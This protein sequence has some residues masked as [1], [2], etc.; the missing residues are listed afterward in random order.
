DAAAV[1]A[2]LV[3]SGAW[4][5]L[6]TRPFNK[7]PAVD[8]EAHSI[9]VTAIDTDPLSV[10]VETALAGRLDDFAA[11]LEA[12]EK[13]T[14]GVVYLCR[15]P[16]ANIAGGASSVRIEE[17]EGPHPAGLVGTH[18]HMLDPVSRGKTVWHVGYND[19][20]DFGELFRTG[21]VPVTRVVALG[22]P[23]VKQPRLLRTRVGAHLGTLVEGELTDGETRVISGSVLSGTT[24]NGDAFGYLGRYARQVTVVLEG[25]AREFMGWLMPGFNIFSIVPTFM[26]ALF[27]E[28]NQRFDMTTDTMG[29]DRAM[30]PIGTYE[31]VMPLDIVPTYLLRSMVAGDLEKA[32]QLGCLE[33]AEEDLALC[34]VVCPGKY[35]Y[36]PI[37]RETLSTIEAEG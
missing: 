27:R 20:A 36:G 9:F 35:D 30:V 18:I 21:R 17:F 26:S 33:L 1:R 25:R 8:G 16:G 3:E 5:A 14:S 31:E 23:A 4:T 34:T 12:I 19:V 13:L 10:D 28:P 32:E 2:L 7:V 24:A 6:R 37:L 22:G 11:G 29:S 15:A